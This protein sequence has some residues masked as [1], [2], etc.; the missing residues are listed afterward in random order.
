MEQETYI[1][2][3]LAKRMPQFAKGGRENGAHL[4]SH[5][6]IHNGTSSVPN[7]SPDANVDVWE[8]L[9]RYEAFLKASLENNSSYNPAALREIMDGFR[10]VLY[11]S[12]QPLHLTHVRFD[13]AINPL[14]LGYEEDCS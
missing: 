11:R 1:F 3:K 13:A 5:K 6:Q 12:V 8:G 14:P 10:E 7:S 9:D 4:K 2:P